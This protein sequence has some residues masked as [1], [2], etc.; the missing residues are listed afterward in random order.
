VKATAHF[1]FLSAAIL[2]FSGRS[3]ATPPTQP[4]QTKATQGE[5]GQA[6]GDERRNAAD[7]SRELRRNLSSSHENHPFD[8]EDR[9]A[10]SGG[11]LDAEDVVLLRRERGSPRWGEAQRAFPVGLSLLGWRADRTA[12]KNEIGFGLTL[13]LPLDASM[14]RPRL[15][16]ID[17]N[18]GRPIAIH[19][20]SRAPH[21]D[22]RIEVT[23]SEMHELVRSSWR[24]LG[25]DHDER[26]ADL[27]HRAR[28]SAV[29]PELRLKVNRTTGQ[30]VRLSPTLDDPSRIEGSGDASM[31]YEA[32]A[33][34]RLD[35]LVFA[36]DEVTLERVRADR[37]DQRAKQTQ[38][39]IELIS[40]WRKAVGRQIDPLTTSTEKLDAEAVIAATSAGLDALTAGEW[41]RQRRE[42]GVD[43]ADSRNEIKNP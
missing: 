17:R 29:L 34:W 37:N 4:A 1:L 27:A 13:S 30:T 42:R 7:D 22:S 25:L 28:V 8:D 6:Q 40:Q 5:D 24:E 32:R 36:D 26:L 20:E 10:E 12:G 16:Q 33:T 9:I 18:A 15:Q 38:R 35:R 31:L 11:D 21:V 39:V 3:A 41:S 14:G 2:F 23:P 19:V 43:L